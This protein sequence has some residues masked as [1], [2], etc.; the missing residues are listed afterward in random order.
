[1]VKNKLRCLFY[2]AV[3]FLLL[4]I[5]LSEPVTAWALDPDKTIT[6][7]V[8]DV[9]QVEDGLP[10]ST[11]TAILQTR[12]GYIWLGTQEGLVRFDGVRFTVFDK[13]NTKNIKDSHILTLFE[14]HEG[15]LWIGT[16]GGGLNRLK[17][18]EFTAYT[19]KEGLSDNMVW[20]ICEDG[21]G[22]IWI[23]TYSGGLN[24]LRDGKFTAYT[25]KDGL[26]NDFVRSIYEDREGSLWI[27]TGEGLNRLRDGKFTAY[28]TKDGLSNDMVWSIYEDRNGSLWI[29]TY[30]GGL[31]RFKDGKFTAFTTK[32][33]LSDDIVKSIYEDREGSIW[34]GTEGGGLN[35]LRDG[36]FT[37]YTTKEGLSNDFVKSI[38]EDR[39]GSLW[40]GTDGGGL[41]RLK[42]DKFTVYTTKEGLSS[43]LVKSIYEDREGSLWIGTGEGLNRLK[44]GKFTV[45][46]TKEGL[47]ND[48]VWSIYEDRK[49]SLWIGTWRGGLN[50][51][52]DGKFTAYTTKDG[53]S[54]D[55]VRSIYEDREGS[56]WIGTDGGGL[57]RLRDGK[58]T[59]YSTK[60]GLSND[61]VR[62]IY[63]DGEGSLWIGTRGGGLNRLKDG[64]FTAY[65]TKEGLF[66]DS[67]WQILEDGKGNLWMSCNN[68]IF[69]VS[70]RELNDFAEGKIS[71]INSISYGEPDGMMS[72]E[73]NGGFQPAGWKSRDGK[74]WFPTIRGVVMINPENIR[75]NKLPPPVLIE[76]VI[77]D[78]RSFA[79]SGVIQISPGNKDF[80]F[81]YTGLSFLVPERVKFKYKL[82]GWNKE[83]ID[84]GTRRT[85]YYTNIPPG[86]YCF[87]VIACNNDGI[88]NEEG[89]SLKIIVP[90]PFWQ[91]WWFRVLLILSILS[92][93]IFIYKLRTRAI[94]RRNEELNEL[95]ISL[96]ISEE[97]YRLLAEQS[98]QILYDY[99]ILTGKI[100]W[101]GDI[102][103]ITGFTL[104]EFQK[105]DISGWEKRI[106]PDDHKAALTLLDKAMKE[107]SNY[108][109]EYRFKHKDGTYFY[110]E[111]SGLFL[112]DEKGK[113][114]RRLGIMKD[115]TMRKQAEA[116]LR[117]HRE[118]LEELVKERT[119]ELE[120]KN[121]KLEKSQQSL[122]L[123][124]E[125]VNESRV[126]LDVSNKKLEAANKELEAFSYSVSHDLRAPLRHI[127]G[128]TKLLNKNIKHI[129]DEKSQNYFD[130]IISASKQMN[131]LIDDL[132]VFSRMSRKDVKKI[133]INMKT[134]IDEAMQIFDSDIKENN[135]SIIV[136]DMPDVNLD[137]S[138]I[139]QAWVNLISNAI[140]FT[141]KE[142]NPEIHI[143]T[144]KDTDGNTI[145]FIKDNGVGFDQKY[146]DKIFG[147]FQRLHSINEFP[148]T[149]IGLA[150][151]KRII[152]KHG[153]DIRAEGKINE[154]ASFFFTLSDA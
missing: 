11:I 131:Q 82:E 54:N 94:R 67:V 109:V 89:A 90:P 14:D 52:R 20:S 115:I 6:Q 63:E 47:S 71:S 24:R 102:Q 75:T 122:A 148:G 80:E 88:W 149:G 103:T 124:L 154:G 34:I 129:I 98:G 136:D 51:L 86:S 69:R 33:G 32:E 37:V 56:L 29:G 45:Y 5:I 92:A 132:L 85:A 10:Q 46:T 4:I 41:N 119:A 146:V 48:M 3:G 91:I 60:E 12:D 84:A 120:E 28:T 39:E 106:H 118:H 147:V 50:R 135:I 108:H 9:W 111:D 121:K 97:K 79:A 133:N 13:K 66:D 138:L 81:H 77:I 15:S 76:H 53:L 125:D 83:W 2:Q 43:D 73:C 1:M 143:G 57:N 25:T 107:C 31:N 112:A 7:Y 117:K 65:T 116:E 38:Y 64:K 126:E 27:G 87:R 58:F 19:T 16:Y 93:A 114:Y 59:V 130:N 142:K 134:V 128:F 21:K 74:L 139:R 55:M 145:F 99:D 23:G 113:A 151:V 42:D 141:G 49:G 61:L 17:D 40:I 153:G 30:S 36:K 44:D 100:G 26:S 127:D 110:M 150:N 105:V 137:V 62:S 22:S 140:K 104:K 35:R 123:L 96:E 8:H 68:G 72:K 70:M 95:N 78:N 144:E 18:K 152:M 101:S